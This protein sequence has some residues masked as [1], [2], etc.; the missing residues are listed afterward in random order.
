ME[1]KPDVVESHKEGRVLKI[2]VTFP[3]ELP[4]EITFTIPIQSTRRCE[5]GKLGGG[6]S[7]PVN[8]KKGLR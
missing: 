3:N 2:S 7:W 4:G 8:R 5:E 6:R 1:K